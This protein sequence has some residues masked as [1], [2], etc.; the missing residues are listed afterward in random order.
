MVMARVAG[1]FGIVIGGY[2][3]LSDPVREWEAAS[4]VSLLHLMGVDQVSDVLPM[5]IL[6]FPSDGAPFSAVVTKS[7]SSLPAVLAVVGL[8]SLI[9]YGPGLRKAWAILCASALIVV[10]NLLRILGSV[11]A[12]LWAGRSSLVL[13]HDWVGTVFGLAYTLIG[14][15][16]LIAVLLPKGKRLETVRL[17]S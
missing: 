11:A 3:L 2:Y 6:V 14:F 4:V 10:C 15:L 7:C 1:C 5:E 16:V 9:L 8:G 13:F 17:S 12:G